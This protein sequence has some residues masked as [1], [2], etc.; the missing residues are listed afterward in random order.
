MTDHSA[1]DLRAC[2]AVLESKPCAYSDV[3]RQFCYENIHE[4]AMPLAHLLKQRTM[5]A[6]LKSY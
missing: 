1:S 6:I 4:C 5:K 2:S 3:L